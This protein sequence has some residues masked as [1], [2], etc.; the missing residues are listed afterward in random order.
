[1]RDKDILTAEEIARLLYKEMHDDLTKEERQRLNSWRYSQ[2]PETQA[3][4]EELTSWPSLEEDLKLFGSFDSHAALRDIRR[5]IKE[6][7]QQK[8]P[9]SI[10]VAVEQPRR[11][12]FSWLLPGGFVFLGLLAGGIFLYVNNQN[13]V[14]PKGANESNGIAA[15]KSAITPG[16]DKAILTLADGHTIELDNASQ[17]QLAMQG[18][19]KVVKLA[20]GQ[21][22]YEV[23]ARDKDAEVHYNTISTP[24]GGQ[25]QIVL[26]DGSRV[27][28]NAGSSL[29][30]PTVFTGKARSVLLSGEGYFQIAKNAFQKFTIQLTPRPGFS[31]GRPEGAPANDLLIEV[32]GTEFDVKAYSED[33]DIRTT[34]VSGSVKVQLGNAS[35]VLKP[36]QQ[37]R[38]ENT[39]SSELQVVS[40]V[41]TEDVAAW[42][43]GFF[44][45]QS[46]SLESVMNQLARWYDV[47]VQYEGGVRPT[48]LLTANMSR[49]NNLTD[50]LKVL[51][52]SGYRFEIRDRTI[53]V[54][55]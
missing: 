32:L 29:Q 22:S 55:Q 37:A 30:F 44:R 26:P 11:R 14:V 19:V 46:A 4:L 16:G 28:L 53:V 51:E 34:L 25:Y 3:F 54:K 39:G 42:R 47:Q 18:G 24:K 41:S 15:R 12:S 38:V 40:N 27:W 48:Q 8:Q 43:D 1:M 23:P 33:K 36:G 50:I 35:S 2:D 10:P 52:I 21:V 6:E 9:E 45:F 13:K 49:K 5:R 7:D 17:G 31:Q 20:D